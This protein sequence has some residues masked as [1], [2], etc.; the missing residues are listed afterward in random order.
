MVDMTRTTASIGQ[1]LVLPDAAGCDTTNVS[2]REESPQLA[3]TMISAIA[4]D[5]KCPAFDDR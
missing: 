3:A 2:E 1:G 5:A 4:T